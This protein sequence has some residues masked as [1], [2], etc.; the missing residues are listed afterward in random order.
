MILGNMILSITK[1]MMLRKGRS[2]TA[3]KIVPSMVKI[4]VFFIDFEERGNLTLNE[5]HVLERI[6]YATLGFQ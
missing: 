2:A 5:K 4:S 3:G 6:V 1:Y